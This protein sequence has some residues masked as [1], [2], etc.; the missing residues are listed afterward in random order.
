M[1]LCTICLCSS[2]AFGLDLD[3]TNGGGPGATGIATSV[4][5]FVAYSGAAGAG[6]YA[7][8]GDGEVMSCV[9]ASSKAA[10]DDAL[11][12]GVRSSMDPLDVDDNGVYQLAADGTAPDQ[13]SVDGHVTT[14]FNTAWH[15]RGGS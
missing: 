12:F 8:G 9:A 15:L 7:N 6:G 13:T 14:N 1:A 3:D 10:P 2:L 4:N 5:S 11:Y